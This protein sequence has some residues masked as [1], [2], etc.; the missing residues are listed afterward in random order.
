MAKSKVTEEARARAT[1]MR[2]VGTSYRDIAA[3]L[4]SQG[5]TENWCKRNLNTVIV[6]DN[7]Y[8]LMEEL[9]PL[10]VRPEGIPRLQFRAKIKAAYGLPSGVT[11]PE[12]IERR[13][14]RALPYDAFIRPDWMEPEFARA[15]HLELVHDATILV[16]RL[17]EMV[18]EFCV[19][20]PTAS[21]WHVRQEIIGHI[22]GSHPASPLVHGKRMVDAVDTI[23][24]RVPQIPPVE[25][26]F[27]DDEEF[28][29]HCI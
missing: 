19:R 7:H 21:I 6:F 18:A 2:S 23:E 8:F 12:A 26:A 17:E 28:D 27:I 20:Y 25:P 13:T 3:E 22:L 9:I 29:H 11:I 5:V 1:Q 15:S 14:K 24:G 4:G 16:D 10:A